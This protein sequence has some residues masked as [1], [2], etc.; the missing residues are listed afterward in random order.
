MKWNAKK[1]KMTSCGFLGITQLSIV[2]LSVQNHD[3]RSEGTMVPVSEACNILAHLCSYEFHCISYF[4]IVAVKAETRMNRR[5]IH[6]RCSSRV[7]IGVVKDEY[8]TPHLWAKEAK[9]VTKQKLRLDARLAY[10][11]LRLLISSSMLIS[12]KKKNSFTLIGIGKATRFL[13]SG[14]F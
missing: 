1:A 12:R 9:A 4:P 5:V 2:K 10:C 8:V 7:R 13:T 11:A 3:F 6:G 14:V